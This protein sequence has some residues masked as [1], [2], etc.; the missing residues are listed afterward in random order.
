MQ[1]YDFCSTKA[2]NRF[3]QIYSTSMRSSV[4][5]PRSMLVRLCH[6][7]MEIH[8]GVVAFGMT[9]DFCA[10]GERHGIHCHHTAH[11]LSKCVCQKHDPP[12]RKAGV[13]HISKQGTST[14]C[15]REG[16]VIQGSGVS[17]HFSSIVSLPS[18]SCSCMLGTVML[19][20]SRRSDLSCQLS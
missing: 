17:C 20:P 1:L 5:L 10:V 12:V 11:L 9:G 6:E 18:L 7:E 14:E 15:H 16:G 19:C 4:G 3:P 13:V 8:E 2:H